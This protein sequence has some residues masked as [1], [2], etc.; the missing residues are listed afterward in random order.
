MAVLETRLQE[1]RGC[2]LGEASDLEV[3]SEPVPYAGK[4]KAASDRKTCSLARPE[5]QDQCD[6]SVS[7]GGTLVAPWPNPQGATLQTLRPT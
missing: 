3:L 7:L 5:G 6:V 4:L 2:F 1:W